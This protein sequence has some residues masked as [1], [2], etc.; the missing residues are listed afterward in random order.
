MDLELIVVDDGSTDGSL[1][2]LRRI[3]DP[4]LRLIVQQRRGVVAAANRATEEACAPV[5]ARMD[6]DDVCHQDR[7][8]AQLQALRER[9][10]EIVGCG[11]RIVDPLGVP[12]SALNRY[13][14]WLNGL[15][16][17]E[18]IDA[19][20]FIE[21]P[22]ANPTSLARREVFELGYREGPWPEDYDLWLRA[23]ALGYRAA[24]VDA[25][26]LDWTDH[27]SR[28]TR[29]HPRYRKEAFERRRRMALIEGPLSGRPTLDLWGAG[30][31]G[32]RWAR[33]LLGQG[34]HI[35]RL[36]D[37]SPRLVGREFEGIPI[38]A[39]DG[40]SPFDGTLLLGAVG[41]Q[42]AR[43]QIRDFARPLGYRDGRELIFVA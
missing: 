4:R 37:V 7:F 19:A 16:E 39:P 5:I 26:L 10:V 8:A 17:P 30:R 43:D 9:N 35:R 38:G 1:E 23:F 41:A 27:S 2:V 3:Q 21:S 40:L 34:V 13:Q 6:A 20:R 24:K 31:T 18:Q 36:I 32:R 12:V 22:I 11:V 28:L 29:T 15:V 42:G 25:I 14:R 33:W